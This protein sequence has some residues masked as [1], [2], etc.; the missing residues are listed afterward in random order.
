MAITRS[1]VSSL[2]PVAYRPCQHLLP[3]W[4]DESARTY[5]TPTHMGIR[6]VRDPGRES[7]P[8]SPGRL[9]KAQPTGC[10][11]MKSHRAPLVDI[12]WKEA[13]PTKSGE[14]SLRI[15]KAHRT[16]GRRPPL[17]EQKVDCPTS[18]INTSVAVSK[19]CFIITQIS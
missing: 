15:A 8:I 19:D 4:A 2:E 17:A 14:I 13:S 3:H 6:T 10:D 11:N 7:D 12:I 5:T 9:K 16:Y 18:C 1:F